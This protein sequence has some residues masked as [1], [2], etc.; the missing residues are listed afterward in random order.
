M[1]RISD[2]KVWLHH[3]F[4][5]CDNLLCILASFDKPCQVKQIRERAKEAGLHIPDKWN[6]SNCLAKS[7]G[8]AIRTSEGWE[9]TNT[10]RQHLRKIGINILSLDAVGVGIELRE[11]LLHI[12]EKMVREFVEEAIKCYEAE[13][14]RSAIVMSWVAVV[15][16]LHNYIHA[17]CLNDFNAEARRVN[18]K[19]KNAKTIDEL[20]RMRESDFLDRIE[21]LSLIGQNVKRELKSCLDRRNACSHP[22]SLQFSANT[23]AHH[24]EILLLNV[25]KCFK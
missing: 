18:S 13:L 24:I 12:K 8:R 20:G 21:A 7:N 17:N 11:E 22:S 23:A 9:L 14:Y 1:L 2:L 4:G 19:W 5:R 16:V 10:G 25:F 15:A 3:D 6:T